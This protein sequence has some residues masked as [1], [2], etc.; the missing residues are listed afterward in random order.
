MP[1]LDDVRSLI[2]TA[3]APRGG[4]KVE[5]TDLTG[6]GDHLQVVVAAATFEGKTRIEQH[7][8]VYAALGDLMTGP[9][10]PVHALALTTVT[11]PLAGSTRRAT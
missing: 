4:A 8:M 1:S 7:R 9:H 6:T 5:V 11:P 10:A 3:F 2:L